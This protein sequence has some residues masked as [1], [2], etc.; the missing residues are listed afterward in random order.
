MMSYLAAGTRQWKQKSFVFLK[1]LTHDF[2]DIC[3][4]YRRHRF[5]LVSM[6]VLPPNVSNFVL[7]FY[8]SPTPASLEMTIFDPAETAESSWLAA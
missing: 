4:D 6:V 3:R 5:L 7:G 2:E 8:L 1:A